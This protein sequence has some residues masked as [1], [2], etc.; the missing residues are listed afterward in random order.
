MSIHPDSVNIAA[1]VPQEWL[2][3]LE[4]L[5]QKTG[6]SIEELIREALAQ[7]LGIEKKISP[8]QTLVNVPLATIQQ[9]LTT[10]KQ[11]VNHLEQLFPQVTTLEAKLFSLEKILIPELSTLPNSQTFTQVVPLDDDEQYDEPDEI[12]TDFLSE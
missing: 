11:K 8:S 1:M 5:S 4:Q 2:V 9:D 6:R 7:Y 10:L 3:K 12:L